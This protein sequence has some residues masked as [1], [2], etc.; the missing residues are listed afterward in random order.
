MLIRSREGELGF[1]ANLAVDPETSQRGLLSSYTEE[2]KR[3]AARINCNF[4]VISRQEHFGAPSRAGI[5]C[6][7]R[8]SWRCQIKT[9]AGAIITFG[10][11]IRSQPSKD[12]VG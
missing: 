6:E 3:P 4:S 5:S 12:M 7:P 1:T 8:D 11:H 2:R 9:E 10:R